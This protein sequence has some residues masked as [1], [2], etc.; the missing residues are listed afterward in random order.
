MVAGQT[1]HV[2]GTYDGVTQR[3][4]VNGV[5]V[6]SGSFS[7]ALNANTASVVVG[8]WDTTSEFVAGTVDDVAV[9]AKALTADPG[10]QPLQPGPGG[11]ARPDNNNDDDPPAA[12]A[13]TAAGATRRRSPL[14]A[15][16][17]TGG[18]ARPRAPSAADSVGTGTGTYR[19]GV[20]TGAPSLLG[21]GHRQP[22]GLLRRRERLGV[23]AQLGRAQPDRGR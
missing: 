4:Y 9:Y 11:S 14:T 15:R 16:S 20:T 21:V 12:P 18:W 6:A 23:G 17:P 8:S 13:P 1:Y 2:V 3:L 5:Q 10:R 22:V 19:N 7:G